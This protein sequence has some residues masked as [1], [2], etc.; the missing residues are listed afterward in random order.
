VKK[1]K[2]TFSVRSNPYS[3]ALIDGNDLEYVG[4]QYWPV[5]PGLEVIV[6]WKPKFS[7]TPYS[8]IP[9]V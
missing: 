3:R 1:P 8:G 6:H 9:I 2:I 4:D 7:I 5:Q